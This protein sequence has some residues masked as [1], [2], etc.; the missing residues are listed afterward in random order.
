MKKWLIIF[1]FVAAGAGV[2]AQMSPAEMQKL[3]KMSPAE[4]E[5]WKEQK[6]KQLSRQA[7]QLSDQYDLKV[8][9]TVLPD[10]ELK[11]PVKDV[12]RLSLITPTIPSMTQLTSAV[13][14]SRKQLENVA[15]PAVVQEVKQVTAQ[16]TPA[17]MEAL[18]IGQWLNNNPVQAMLLS[19]SSALKSPQEPA[20]WNNLAALYNMIGLEQKA[21][22]ILQYWLEKMPGNPMLLNNMGQAYLGMGDIE[23]AKGYLQKC[24]DADDMDPEANHA[25]GMIAA[26]SREV[27]KAMEYFEKELQI[28]YRRS[29][30]AQIRRMG[31]SV[32]MLRLRAQRRNVPHRDLF[33]EIGLSKFSIPRLPTAAEQ[34]VKWQAD[35]AGV[36]KSLQ[37]EY[38]FWSTAGVLTKEQQEAEG[39]KYPGVYADLANELF[40]EHGDL[41]AHLLGLVRNDGEVSLLK[42]MVEGYYTRLSQAVCPTPPP[43]PEGGD[44]LIKAYAKKCCDL[45]TPIIDAYMS[46]RNGWMQTRLDE[47]V[48][49]WKS[50]ING[51]VDIASLDP[52][53]GNK[54]MVYHAVAEYFA[55]L[56][57]VQTAVAQEG[58]P[59][60][61]MVKMT[62]EEADEIIAASHDLQLN[63]PPWLN[64]KLDLTMVKLSADCS[65]YGIEGGEGLMGGYEKNFKTGVSTLSVGMGVKGSFGAAKASAVQMIYVSIDNNNQMTDIGLR[66]SAGGSIGYT[67]DGVI[68]DIGK[69]GT[70]LAG[71]EGGYTLGLESGFKAGI[72]GKG[73]MKDFIKLET[74]LPFK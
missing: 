74:S 55:F 32:N 66:G 9:E 3:S 51:L 21:V 60:E 57:G 10:Y 42:E 45:H 29:T 40:S 16:Q 39:R 46:E 33:T 28:A 15:T 26:F 14:S 2:Q 63:C 20:A 41:Y 44:A 48:A 6:L 61:C 56:L 37:A 31:R 54:R 22:P 58:L 7:K 4:L 53:A 34:T 69:I 25:M 68:G 65:K 1:L 27:D 71:V 18:S 8:D 52:D 64:I 23:K 36:A 67:T 72:T 47:T 24:L 73:V 62:A 30:L 38:I 59:G 5:K 19:M 49:N 11:L 12:Q 70:T 17:Q 35:M 50:Y 43:N 13:A